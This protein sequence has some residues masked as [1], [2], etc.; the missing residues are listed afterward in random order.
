MADWHCGTGP[1]LLL[2]ALGLGAGGLGGQTAPP[3]NIVLVTLDG[4]RQTDL[5]G[6][7]DASVVALADDSG[8]ED[9]A[10]VWRAYWRDSPEERRRAVMP[11]F[12]DSLAPKGLVLGNRARGSVGSITNSQGFSAPGYLEILTGRAQPEVTSNDPIRYPYRTVLQFARRRLG[13][14]R[15]QVVTFASWENFREYVSSEAGEVYVNAGF[16]TVPEPF[17]TPVLARLTALQSRAL[18]VWEGSRLDAFT[19]SLALEYLRRHR[20]RVL[21]LAFND[22]DDFAHQRRYDRVLDALH[23]ADA[24]LQ[25][26]WQTLQSLAAYRGRT[27]LIITTDHGRGRTPRDWT[28]HGQEVSG[29]EEIWLAVVGPWT[30]RMGE[31]P[32]RAVTQSQVAGTLLTCLGL[33]PAE[34][35]PGAGAPVE[36]ACR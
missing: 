36:G 34:F 1:G 28:D 13:L 27:T 25:E 35:D 11:F 21:Y 4:V 5:F 12:W 7:M 9:S 19:G 15:M 30:P 8:I 18:P 14:G 26:L 10:R 22:T 20:P 31:V 32:D 2:L 17:D 16:D 23:N 24:F 29:S 33:A 6:G 3:R